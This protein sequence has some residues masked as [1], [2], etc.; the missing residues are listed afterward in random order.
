MS[1][2]LRI[3]GE[4]AQVELR[5]LADF[6]SQCDKKLTHDRVEVPDDPASPWTKIE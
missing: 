6:C 1:G 2:G 5:V 4:T 3:N